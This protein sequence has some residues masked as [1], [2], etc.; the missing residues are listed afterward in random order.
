MDNKKAT[1]LPFHAINQFMVPEYRLSVLQR[2]FSGFEKLPGPRKSAINGLVKR[3]VSVPGFRNSGVAPVSLKVKSSVGVF[4][5]SAEFTS[6]VIMAW[7]E[8]NP[9]LRQQVYDLLVDR[10]WEVLPADAD[11]TRLP[12]FLTAWPKGENFDVL[13]KAFLE[14]HPDKTASDDDVRLMVVWL[15]G[16]LPYD[17]PEDESPANEP[18]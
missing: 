1:F 18:A 8:L 13:D 6:Q 2:V 10:S 9:D 4:E 17:V 12:G 15:S 14:T 16:R 7:S 11:R 3:L 5:R